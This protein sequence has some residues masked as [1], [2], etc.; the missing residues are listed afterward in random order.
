VTNSEGF[1]AIVARMLTSGWLD[2][3]SGKA[4]AHLREEVERAATEGATWAQSLLW[5]AMHDFFRRLWVRE[6]KRP[7]Y[8]F[9][10]S[11]TGEVLDVP[12]SYSKPVRRPDGTRTRAFQPALVRGVTW[13]EAA[14]IV[15]GLRRQ[16]NRL[17][18]AVLFWQAIVDLRND[19]PQA[20]SPGEAC[21]LAGI[22]L[23]ATVIAGLA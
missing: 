3:P 2:Q 15:S 13:E 4:G 12:Q 16:R 17:D 23:D 9:W 1:R 20:A 19:F 7:R 11:H 21:D 5:Q 8:S 6:V 18:V 10:V 14:M 22:D